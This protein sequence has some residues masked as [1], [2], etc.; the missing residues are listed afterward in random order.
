MTI[1]VSNFR[2]IYSSDGS[3]QYSST[4]EA[5][6]FAH[7]HPYKASYENTNHKQYIYES[8]LQ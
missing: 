1:F 6:G 7:T 5:L 2:L 3:V 8:S 4:A